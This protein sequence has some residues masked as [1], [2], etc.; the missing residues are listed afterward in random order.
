MFLLSTKVVMLSQYLLWTQILI[1]KPISFHSTNRLSMYSC[2]IVTYYHVNASS[3]NNKATKQFT[4]L[5]VVKIFIIHYKCTHS[6]PLQL[7]STNEIS[8]R[9]TRLISV[10]IKMKISVNY[11][12]KQIITFVLYKRGS[13]IGTWGTLKNLFEQHVVTTLEVTI[14]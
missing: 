11:H 7:A 12:D 4:L 10:C 13:C 9:I 8:L 6:I 5:L 1:L 3:R 2:K 14:L